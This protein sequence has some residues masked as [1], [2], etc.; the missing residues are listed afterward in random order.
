MDNYDKIISL[1][2]SRVVKD[3]TDIPKVYLHKWLALGQTEYLCLNGTLSD[4]H[5]KLTDAQ[6]YAQAIKEWYGISLAVRRERAQAKKAKADLIDAE[7]LLLDAKT[8]SELLRAEALKEEAEISLLSKLV[9]AEDLVRQLNAYEKA[10]LS[11]K[12]KVEAQ[13]PLG[14]EQAEQDN[15]EAVFR[16][17][18]NKEKLMGLSRER[19]DNIPL[20]AHRKAELGYDYGRIDAIA[21]LMI[22]NEEACKKIAGAWEQNLIEHQKQN[23]KQ[24]IA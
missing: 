17:R 10:Y 21:P 16:Y 3:G 14:I 24:E 11:L 8:P 20:P 19:T 2:D 12:D 18:M 23:E 4:G 9:N 13:Y 22:E 1:S 6:K 15:W 7:K 5:E